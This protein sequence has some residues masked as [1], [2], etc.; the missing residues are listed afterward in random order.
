VAIRRSGGRGGAEGGGDRLEERVVEAEIALVALAGPA[1]NGLDLCLC[2]V[3]AS[4][5]RGT[6]DAKAVSTE[7]I[8]VEPESDDALLDA[9][10][11]RAVAKRRANAIDLE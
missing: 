4:K 2:E 6:A 5:L 1:T 3:G 10:K 9:V 11:Q 7:E 8:W